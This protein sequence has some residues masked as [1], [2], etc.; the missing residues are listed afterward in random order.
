M[1]PVRTRRAGLLVHL[2]IMM[3]CTRA[4]LAV[5]SGVIAGVLACGSTDGGG[6]LFQPLAPP[7]QVQDVPPETQPLPLTPIV[8][9]PVVPDPPEGAVPGGVAPPLVTP[10]PQTETGRCRP[11]L[12]V[13]GAPQSISEAIILMNTLPKPT[14]LACFLEALDRPLTLYLTKSNQSLQ[15]SPGARSPRTFVL[16]GNMAMSVVFEGSAS[17]TLELGFRPTPARSIKAEIEFPLTRDVN[18]AMLFDRIRVTPRTTLCGACH[19]GEEHKDFPGFPSGVF[20]SDVFSPFDIEEVSI[21]SAQ[22][23]AERCDE[24]AEPYRCGLLAAI[25][26]HGELLPGALPDVE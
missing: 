1:R 19:V 23:E 26:D 17:N 25:F 7:G 9:P 11:A 10:P 24:V 18:E 2:R 20:E 8:V 5:C 12:G 21:A 4:H 6:E 14:T 22:L 15:P 3:R 16:R 13:S